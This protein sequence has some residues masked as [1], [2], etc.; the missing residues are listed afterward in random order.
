ME[1]INLPGDW[2]DRIG[3]ISVGRASASF[4]LGAWELAA[5]GQHISKTLTTEFTTENTT[6]SSWTNEFNLSYE[7]KTGIS[8]EGAS[9]EE[10]ISSSY[11]STIENS[12][13]EVI[14]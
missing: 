13:Q 12:T 7:V 8:F 1:C 9:E 6:S 10:T 3:S 2:T 5:T 14:S 11:T 4:A